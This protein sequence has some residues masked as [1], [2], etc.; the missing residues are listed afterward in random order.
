MSVQPTELVQQMKPYVPGEQP[1]D[2]E[3]IKLNTNENPYPPSPEVI[4]AM[5]EAEL[6]RMRLYPDPLCTKLRTIIAEKHHTTKDHIF[7]GNGSDE[8]LRLLF[9][10]YFSAENRLVITNPSYSLYPVLADTFG[11]PTKVVEL[12]PEGEL[13]QLENLQA[14]KGFVLS[15]PNPPLGVFYPREEIAALMDSAPDNLFI[16]D[17]AYVDF[18]EG[19][20]TE[21]IRKRDNVVIC[22]SLS[23][24]YSLAGIRAGYAFAP[25]PLIANL[26]KIKDSYNVNYLTQT[27][28]CAAIQ[29]NAYFRKTVSR[30]KEDREYLTQELRRAGYKVYPSQGNFVFAEGEDGRQLY[31]KLKERKILVRYFD[32]PRLKRGVR[33]TV[34][35]HQEIQAL[36]NALPAIN[37]PDSS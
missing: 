24:S 21:L 37:H 20:A 23:K 7:V 25:A 18:A 31:E 3:Y 6:E 2:G 36:L 34:G 11:I 13:P 12:G 16:I 33:I 4:R 19:D 9:Q 29:S 35:T 14:C 27:A 8:V 30:I 1:R 10:A 26:F 22:R 32:T 5:R 17:E 15:N 28:A